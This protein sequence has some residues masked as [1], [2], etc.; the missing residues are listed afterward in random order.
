M[1]PTGDSTR[2]DQDLSA[3]D[4]A[5]ETWVWELPFLAL[6]GFLLV[7]F[8]RP[9]EFFPPLEKARLAIVFFLA[10]LAPGS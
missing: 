9:G 3:A 7:L 1:R 5:R 4:P 10:S 6:S 8:L 2:S